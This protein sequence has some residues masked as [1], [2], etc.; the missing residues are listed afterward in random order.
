MIGANGGFV[1]TTT[2][3][4]SFSVTQAVTKG[5]LSALLVSPMVRAPLLLQHMDYHAMA[6][7]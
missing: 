7:P 4:C 5:V 3:V 6:W 2:L 1:D